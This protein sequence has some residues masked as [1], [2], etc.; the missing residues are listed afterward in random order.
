MA[1]VVV[2]KVIIDEELSLTFDGG[3]LGNSHDW[4]VV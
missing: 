3:R 2:V 1:V 4:K